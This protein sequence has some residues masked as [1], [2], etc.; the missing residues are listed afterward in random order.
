MK[1]CIRYVVVESGQLIRC[2]NRR[3]DGSHY[4]A[5]HDLEHKQ[6]KADRI[7]ALQSQLYLTQQLKEIYRDR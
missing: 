4:C 3:A 6:R 2:A 5:R 1:Y 7:A